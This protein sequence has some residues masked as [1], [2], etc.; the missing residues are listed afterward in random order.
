MRHVAAYQVI[1]RMELLGESVGAATGTV[2][3]HID[4]DKGEGGL[5][6]IGPR[7]EVSMPF[8]TSGMY[9]AAIDAWGKREV[10]VL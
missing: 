10:G 6:A 1:A 4:D 7:G 2:M 5:I 8:N 9:R 3:Q